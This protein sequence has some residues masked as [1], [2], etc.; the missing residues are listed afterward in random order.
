MSDISNIGLTKPCGKEL[1][2]E[3][4]HFVKWAP[5]T[6]YFNIYIRQVHLFEGA[7]TQKLIVPIHAEMNLICQVILRICYSHQ[8]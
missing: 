6:P 4:L 1:F 8:N 3:I 5:S 2:E 7:L